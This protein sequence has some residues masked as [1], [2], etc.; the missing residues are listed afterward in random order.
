MTEPTH[1]NALEPGYK[2]HWYEIQSVLGQGGF[3]ITYLALDT[4]LD[5]LVA[6]KEYLPSDF[7]VR[8][9]DSSVHPLSGDTQPQF[10]WGLDRFI[11]EAKILSKF[12]HP[13]IVR[14]FAVF[15]E[16]NTGYLIMPY[17]KGD[18]LQTLLKDKKTLDQSSLLKIIEPILDGLEMVHEHEFIHRDIKPD[19]IF[20]RE[21]GSPVLLDFGSARQAATGQVKTLTTLV[22]PGYAPFEQYYSKSDEQGPWTDIY[23]LGATLYRAITGRAPLDAVD[24]SKSILDGSEDTFRS[25]MKVGVGHYTEQFLYAI[26]HAINFKPADRPQNISEWRCEFDFNLDNIETVI[27]GTHENITIQSKQ[28]EGSKNSNIKK[29]AMTLVVLIVLVA[30]AIYAFVMNNKP[31][32]ELQVVTVVTSHSETTKAVVE[33]PLPS[34]MVEV[35]PQIDLDADSSVDEDARLTEIDKQQQEAQSQRDEENRLAAQRQAAE[36]KRIAKEKQLEEAVEQQE[37]ENKIVA[38]RADFEQRY[39]IKKDSLSFIDNVSARDLNQVSSK[40]I[41]ATVSSK[42]DGWQNSG[43]TIKRGHTYT[44]SARGEWRMAPLCPL[45]GP[46]GDD[47]YTMVC[48]D[49]GY[50]SVANRSHAALIGKIGQNALGFYIGNDFTFT[51][52]TDGVLYLACNDAPKFFFDNE[53]S[54]SIVISLEK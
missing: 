7:A 33:E 54:L 31:S 52:G 35:Q 23:G 2:L 32:D 25:A 9:G 27:S 49:V 37:I 46:S 28:H 22:S 19:N 40:E 21:D 8:D 16:N 50:Q 11:S 17:E 42:I 48:W 45:T 39:A 3:G 36:A 44:I 18:S 26:D 30:A 12:E 43:V 41:S 29:M 4:N 47:L 15:E 5:R 24:R 34:P 1:R 53:G 14:I 10:E 6:I 20:I 13:N 38:S 51:A